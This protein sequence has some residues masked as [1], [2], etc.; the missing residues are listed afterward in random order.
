[1]I[2]YTCKHWP[3]PRFPRLLTIHW[4]IDR[5]LHSLSIVRMRKID[6]MR[7]TVLCLVTLT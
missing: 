4:T 6:R 1:M 2:I 3:L 7:T 5:L